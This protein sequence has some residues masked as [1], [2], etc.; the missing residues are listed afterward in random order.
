MRMIPGFTAEAA[1]R[2]M[3]SYRRTGMNWSPT[4]GV[5]V[6]QLMMTIPFWRTGEDGGGWTTFTVDLPDDPGGGRGPNQGSGDPRIDAQ[7]RARCNRLKTPQAR[8]A[9]LDLC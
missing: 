8:R 2:P 3:L 7:C 5:V 4:G 6:P 9:C 1:C